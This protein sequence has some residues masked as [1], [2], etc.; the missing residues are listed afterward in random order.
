MNNELIRWDGGLVVDGDLYTQKGLFAWAEE[1]LPY[2]SWTLTVTDKEFEQTGGAIFE[3]NMDGTVKHHGV[4]IMTDGD[5]EKVKN[6]L[7]TYSRFTQ[8]LCLNNM[9]IYS[10]SHYNNEVTDG[11]GNVVSTEGRKGLAQYLSSTLETGDITWRVD[12]EV[13]HCDQFGYCKDAS[14]I[15][16]DFSKFFDT[17][18][19][20]TMVDVDDVTNRI[21]VFKNGLYRTFYW[22]TVSGDVFMDEMDGDLFMAGASNAFQIFTAVNF[23]WRNDLIIEYTFNYGEKSW[24]LQFNAYDGT[25]YEN[26]TEY[27]HQTFDSIYNEARLRFV[28]RV[29]W[30]INGR[31][32]TIYHDGRC[33]W[34][35]GSAVEME[36]DCNIDSLRTYLD[37]SWGGVTTHIT[38]VHLDEVD[39][40]T[41]Y[42]NGTLVNKATGEVMGAEFNNLSDCELFFQ[43]LFE[44]EGDVVIAYFRF[45]GELQP[46]LTKKFYLGDDQDSILDAQ[47]NVVCSGGIEGL[48]D[49]LDGSVKYTYHSFYFDDRMVLQFADRDGQLFDITD[50][51]NMMEVDFTGF[52][53]AEA[54]LDDLEA[55]MSVPFIKTRVTGEDWLENDLTSGWFKIFS[56][57]DNNT[58]FVT[59]VGNDTDIII[60]GAASY[61]EATIKLGEWYAAQQDL[62]V[63]VTVNIPEQ[64]DH[65]TPEDNVFLWHR[66]GDKSVVV[67]DNA[68]D[69]FM[70]EA[71]SVADIGKFFESISAWNN[72]EIDVNDGET[73]FFLIGNDVYYSENGTFFCEGYTEGCIEEKYIGV[74]KTF[75]LKLDHEMSKTYGIS[76][77]AYFVGYL[78]KSLNKTYI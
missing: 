58:F 72:T 3:G 53:S 45:Q 23:F 28:D 55:S 47:G 51:D 7:N 34:A 5:I 57:G 22:N 15:T 46:E 62:P 48:R 24:S 59:N 8:I 56:I 16:A 36:G 13:F 31:Q 35:D 37:G 65:L 39:Y 52:E 61:D 71:D 70:D 20:F 69:I 10:W 76:D 21:K 17:A 63:R 6:L 11:E 49:Y 41:Y 50:K 73:F 42:H 66:D 4:V 26:G 19:S 25:W 33:E 29:L 27:E 60:E 44:C 1:N 14:G 54:Y 2:E 67:F 30:T 38:V 40:F 32:F 68:T 12:D 74:T 43:D 78:C 75:L 18:S 77:D 64:E 9:K